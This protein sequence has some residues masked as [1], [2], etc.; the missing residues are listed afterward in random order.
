M[1]VNARSR[2]PMPSSHLVLVVEDDADFREAL[3]SALEHAGYEVIAAVNGAAALQL[4]Q[5]QIV[6][7]VVIL[8]LMMPVMDGRTFREHQLADPALASIPVI[9]LSAEAKAAELGTS[10]GVHAVL[11]KPVDLEALL[12]ALDALC[13]E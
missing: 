5:W 4:L 1:R 6:P 7:S 12:H 3:V 11:R 10:P 8:D 13:P 9:V 2:R